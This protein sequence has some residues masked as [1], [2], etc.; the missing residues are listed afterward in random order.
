MGDDVQIHIDDSFRNLIPPLTS[1]ERESLE[2]AITTEGCRD[3]ITV[4]KDHGILLDGHN[5]FEICERNGISYQVFELP[6]STEAEAKSWM[7]RN[8]FGR[9]NLSDAMRIKLAL[10]LKE[11]MAEQAKIKMSESGKK[12]GRPNKSSGKNPGINLSQ[13]FREPR[14]TDALARLAGVSRCTL[15]KGEKVL[16]S[17]QAEIIQKYERGDISTDRALR[18]VKQAAVTDEPEEKPPKPKRFDI[19]QT[20]AQVAKAIRDYDTAPQELRV[21]LAQFL[22]Y[23]AGRLRHVFE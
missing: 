9:R 2:S 12:G 4:W 16:T 17:G 7:I 22:E 3:P 21:Q 6:F 14:T 19:E 23:R 11:Q 10:A 13:G 15:E 18:F 1:S 5:R 20:K 8:Q